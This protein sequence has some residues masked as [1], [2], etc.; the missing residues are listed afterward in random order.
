[1]KYRS[2]YE[3]VCKSVGANLVCNTATER[4]PNARNGRVWPVDM[5]LC[6]L[7]GGVALSLALS[8]CTMSSGPADSASQTDAETSG[9]SSEQPSTVRLPS[10][11][12]SR[13]AAVPIASLAADRAQETVAVSGEVAQRV[14]VLD[15]WLYQVQDETGSLWV[16]TNQSEPV[17]GAAVTVEG[18]L[19]YES[20]VVEGIDAGE[21]YLEETTYRQEER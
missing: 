15:G 4:I 8:G 2:V 18:T 6:L 7:A 21:V 3:F 20:I 13:R 9:P 19:R 1:M 16:V 17:M 12:L 14:A 5:R 10:I 11:R